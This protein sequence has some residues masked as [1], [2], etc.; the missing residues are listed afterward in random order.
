MFDDEITSKWRK[1]I[2]DSG[3]DVSPKMMD[4]I[5]KELQ[6]KA[7]VFQKTGEIIAFDPGVVK[8]DTAV[9]AELRQALREAVRPLEDV[10]EDQRDYHPGSN[11]KVVDLVHPSLFPVVYGRSRIL[12]DKTIGL[13]DCLHNVGPAKLL[14]VH[15]EDKNG[16]L[17]LLYIMNFEPI[18]RK[19][20]WMPCDVEFADGGECR[21]V[22]YINNL[23]P[24]EHR[25][26][27]EV[28]E[29]VLARTIPLWNTTL[30]MATN[31]LNRIEYSEVQYCAES[32]HSIDYVGHPDPEQ[33]QEYEEESGEFWDHEEW[34]RNRPI[35]LPEPGKFSPSSLPSDREVRLQQTFAERGLQVIVKL[36]NI[37]LTPE[38]PQ[39][40]GGTWHVEG[41][42]V[43]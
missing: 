40:D 9:P 24:K 16:P 20:Q 15:P 26:L 32:V 4:W 2:D 36:A 7:G 31:E 14:P 19:F 5:V 28:L 22:S 35:I 30:T 38:N 25:T 41:Q 42:F 12:P 17:R 13:D 11:N 34:E 37:E 33:K 29:K 10:P 23:H 18:S 8:S 39:Y 21:I 6:Y 3:Q 1:E 27:Y 43:R